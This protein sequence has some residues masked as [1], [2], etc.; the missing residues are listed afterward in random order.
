MQKMQRIRR[1]TNKD[2]CIK[3]ASPTEQPAERI[4]FVPSVPI[5][6]LIYLA[7]TAPD[8]VLA[9][10][11]S[12]FFQHFECKSRKQIFQQ[13]KV[14][15]LIKIIFFRSTVQLCL[16]EV[17]QDLSG[18]IRMLFQNNAL[19]VLVFGT[20]L[21]NIREQGQHQRRPDDRKH[22]LVRNRRK[23]HVVQI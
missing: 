4:F 9:Q 12:L 18:G 7:D 2:L 15:G 10:I 23:A 22:L 5:T 8:L 19:D 14:G 6:V 13:H 20:V 11:Q 17:A 1:K 16:K 21:F 3:T